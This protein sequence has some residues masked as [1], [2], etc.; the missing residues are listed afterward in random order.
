M[1]RTTASSPPTSM[2]ISRV[3]EQ[4]RTLIGDRRSVPFQPAGGRKPGGGA[5][6]LSSRSI[7]SSPVIWAVCSPAMR[8]R[9]PAANSLDIAVRFDLLMGPWDQD[10]VARGAVRCVLPLHSHGHEAGQRLVIGEPVRFGFPKNA[11]EG[12]AHPVLA[13]GIGDEAG[14]MR[15]ILAAVGKD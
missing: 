1:R 13:S 6:K 5:L 15:C 8:G 4:A 3:G 9:R 12:A 2:P 11:N 14:L 7:L 10:A